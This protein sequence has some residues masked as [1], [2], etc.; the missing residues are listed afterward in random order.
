MNAGIKEKME[1]SYP[2]CRSC[3]EVGM[4]DEMIKAMNGE[5]G[6]DAF[7]DLLSTRIAAE[8]LPPFLVDLARLERAVHK[9]KNKAC[10]FAPQDQPAV[11]PSLHR[12]SLKFHQALKILEDIYDFCKSRNVRGQ[13]S[14]TGG[15]PLLYPRFMELYRA[16]SNL[17]FALAILGNPAQR[18]KIKRIVAVESPV[19]YQ[20]SLEGLRTHNPSPIGNALEEGIAAVYD[21]EAARRYRAGCAACTGCTVRPVCGGCLAVSHS[22]GL[23]IFEARDP[24]CIMP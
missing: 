4:W 2:H 13:V 11:N 12:H 3:I 7:L 16:A 9:A 15:N 14:F 5:E 8:N 10:S 24:F 22:F 21:S 1:E 23:D 6:R 17:G 18:T 20:V 19:F